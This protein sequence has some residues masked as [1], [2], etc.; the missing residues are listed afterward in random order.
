MKDLQIFVEVAQPRRQRDRSG[1][2]EV[3]TPKSHRQRGSRVIPREVIAALLEHLD[4]GLR[5]GLAKFDSGTRFVTN[6][7]SV[8]ANQCGKLDEKKLLGHPIRPLNG[9]GQQIMCSLPSAASKSDS[10]L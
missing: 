9:S 10:L 4:H 6:F 2:L 7:I 3:G 8:M 5:R 1:I